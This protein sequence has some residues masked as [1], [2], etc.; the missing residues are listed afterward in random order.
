MEPKIKEKA[1]DPNIEQDILKRWDEEKLYNFDL[2]AGKP[3]VIDTP[4]PYPRL[5]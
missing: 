2:N 5:A 3:F 4:P 1:W